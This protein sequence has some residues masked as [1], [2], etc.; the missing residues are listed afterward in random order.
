MGF[1]LLPPA[2]HSLPASF[3]AFFDTG[4]RARSGWIAGRPLYPGDRVTRRGNG[5]YTLAISGR[6]RVDPTPQQLRFCTR[7]RAHVCPPLAQFGAR[8]PRGLAAG[9]RDACQM[10]ARRGDPDGTK[11]DT[12]SATGHGSD[13]S[14]LSA[15][16]R[17]DPGVPNTSPFPMHGPAISTARPMASRPSVRSR[18]FQVSSWR[19]ASAATASG[20]GREPG[21]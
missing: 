3:R 11:P 13:Q 12:R 8:R 7:I 18:A 19:P 6:A 2:R 5:G 10:G 15:R 21:I 4:R 16:L 9:P 17:A 20:S 1:V 14:H